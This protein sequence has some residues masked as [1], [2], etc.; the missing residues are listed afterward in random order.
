MGESV[1]STVP[2]Q[3]KYRNHGLAVRASKTVLSTINIFTCTVKAGWGR[4]GALQSGWYPPH[5]TPA[6]TL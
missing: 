6:L 3:Q 2:S 4:D 5:E 1:S